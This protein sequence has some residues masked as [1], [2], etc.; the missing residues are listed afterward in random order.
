[1]KVGEFLRKTAA[2]YK[3][4]SIS[5]SDLFFKRCS[6]L[7]EMGFDFLRKSPKTIRDI[8]LDNDVD[9]EDLKK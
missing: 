5:S 7:Q 8:A 1:M 9:L 4:G 2:S 3:N 6:E